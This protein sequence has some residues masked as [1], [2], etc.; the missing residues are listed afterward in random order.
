MKILKR[1]FFK[2]NAITV[3]K[4]LLG[5]ILFTNVENKLTGGIIVEVEAYSGFDDPANHG[6]IG[7]TKRNEPI[8]CEGGIIY[9]YLNYGIHYLLNIVADKKDFPASVFIRAIEPL[10]GI[11]IMMKRRNMKSIKN[12]TNGPAKLTKALG[13]DLSF[14]KESIE[15]KRIFISEENYIKNFKIVQTQRI[16]ISRGKNLLRRFLIKDNKF[17]STNYS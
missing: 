14:N 5:K 13:I 9:V 7:K 10:V 11:E 4:E 12:L 3:A 6:F 2:R 8:F 17:I 15:S 1:E 16:G